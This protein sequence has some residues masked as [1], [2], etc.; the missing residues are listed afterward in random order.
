[1]PCNHQITTRRCSEFPARRDA[2][3]RIAPFV[4]HRQLQSQRRN[5]QHACKIIAFP[6]TLRF[7]A[8]ALR[9]RLV[10]FGRRHFRRCFFRRR[11]CGRFFLSLGDFRL[12]AQQQALGFLSGARVIRPIVRKQEQC[13]K[14]QHCSQNHNHN[15]RFFRHS[16]SSSTTRSRR[17]S[18]GSRLQRPA[19]TPAS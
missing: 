6:F 8:F 12:C 1:M 17:E 10:C 11:G 3:P 13:R 15:A 18:Q 7:C 9:K 19:R 2:Q 14:N 4:D 16:F 5:G